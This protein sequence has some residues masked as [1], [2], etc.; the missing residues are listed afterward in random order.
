MEL[1]KLTL[2]RLNNN[3]TL[4]V[5]LNRLLLQDK[6][7][8]SDKLKIKSTDGTNSR[9]FQSLSAC[10]SCPQIK[11]TIHALNQDKV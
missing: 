6:L 8:L 5:K 3:L 10:R 11:N 7:F 1:S 9:I 2:W 4:L